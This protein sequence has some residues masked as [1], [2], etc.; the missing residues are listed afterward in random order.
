[1]AFPIKDVRFT[2]RRNGSGAPTMYPRL[3]RDRS[4][5]PKVDI[6]IQYFESMVGRERRELEPEV[7]VHFFGDHKLA[8]CMV[9]CLARAYRYRSPGFEDIVSAAGLRRLQRA[10][11]PS[12]R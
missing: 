6:A 10:G 8:R 7:L 2:S 11:I 4:I 9:A 1:M 5:L 3:L 12:P